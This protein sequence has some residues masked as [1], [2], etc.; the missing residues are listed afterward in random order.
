[1]TRL[2]PLSI[3]LLALAGAPGCSQQTAE[4]KGKALATE[5]I[6]L[7]KGVGD[8]LTEKG[9]G[10]AQS[11]AQGTGSVFQGMDEGFGKA[12]EW[13]FTNGADMEKAGLKVTRVDRA[14]SGADSEHSV[15]AYLVATGAANGSL[16]MIAYDQDKREVARTRSPVTMEAGSGRYETLTLDS[17]SPMKAIREVAFDFLPDASNK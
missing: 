8:A 4:E 17:R 3:C 12:F 6:D 5:K 9:K 2:L 1:M 16:T 13:R 7:I 10:A 14:G 15:N 11:V